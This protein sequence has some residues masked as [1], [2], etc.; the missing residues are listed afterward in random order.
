[1]LPNKKGSHYYH[2]VTDPV[3][4]NRNLQIRDRGTMVSQMMCE[5]STT[6]WLDLRPTPR[7]LLGGQEPETG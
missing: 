3:T 5:K 7:L 6:F 1:M 4:Y 2:L